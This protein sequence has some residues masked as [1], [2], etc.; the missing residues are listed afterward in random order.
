M[1]EFPGLIYVIGIEQRIHFVGRAVNSTDFVKC[2]S[3][4]FFVCLENYMHFVRSK[5]NEL[6]AMP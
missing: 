2:D 3:G 4:F 1:N 5:C 6:Y